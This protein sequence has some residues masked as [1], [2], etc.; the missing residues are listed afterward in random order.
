MKT[1]YKFIH[2]YDYTEEG[3]EKAEIC[4]EIDTEYCQK[5]VDT[6]VVFLRRCGFSEKGI[7]E[8][9]ANVELYLE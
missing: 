8:A 9:L 3:L 7:D 6:F 2:E 4:I 5:V 1:Y